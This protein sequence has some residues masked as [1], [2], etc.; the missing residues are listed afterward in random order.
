[1]P[2]N[3]T[4]RSVRDVQAGQVEICDVPQFA[5]VVNLAC[6]SN[7]KAV[8][9]VVISSAEAVIQQAWPRLEGPPHPP[10]QNARLFKL[11]GLRS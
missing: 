6:A 4:Q 11:L 5:S 1:M 8:K 7:K 10:H 2:D 9:P 3:Q